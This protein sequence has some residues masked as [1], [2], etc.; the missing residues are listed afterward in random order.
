MS[1][2]KEITLVSKRNDPMGTVQEGF[3]KICTFI[4]PG[5]SWESHLTIIVCSQN[6]SIQKYPLKAFCR[7]GGRLECTMVTLADIVAII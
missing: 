4:Y 2:T 6:E 7:G 1:E 5:V 3:S